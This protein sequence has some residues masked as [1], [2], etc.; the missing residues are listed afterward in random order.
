M[1][2]KKE[3]TV[4]RNYGG[5]WFKTSTYYMPSTVWHLAFIISLIFQNSSSGCYC[6][7]KIGS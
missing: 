1:S 6:N 2:E 4:E 7:D 5:G 3:I